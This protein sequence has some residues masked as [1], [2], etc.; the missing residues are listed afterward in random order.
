[1]PSCKFSARLL[2][3]GPGGGWTFIEI[4]VNTA[5]LFG[6]KG[7]VSVKGTINGFAFASSIFPKGDGT[8]TMMVNKAMQA[9]GKVA[10]GE[11]AKFTLEKDETPRT[12]MVPPVLTKLLKSNQ[13][14][15]LYFEKLS[16]SHRKAYVEFI[17]E[18]KK[19]ETRL[20]RAEKTVAMLAAGKKLM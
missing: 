19:E 17:T 20:R 11:V 14:A 3:E 6:T 8:H 10:P 13:P 1:M 16:P 5:E 4:P 2:S 7:R 12:V 15:R 9:G 18:A